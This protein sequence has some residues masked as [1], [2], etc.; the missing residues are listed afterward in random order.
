MRADHIDQGAAEQLG[1][2]LLMAVDQVTKPKRPRWSELPD[3]PTCDSTGYIDGP[4]EE[5]FGQIYAT[6]KPC[7]DCPRIVSRVAA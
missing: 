2:A 1:R 7:R 5:A 4:L 6:V 3:C